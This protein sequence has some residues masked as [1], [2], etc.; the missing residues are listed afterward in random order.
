MTPH[1]EVKLYRAPLASACSVSTRR[2]S[3]IAGSTA[4]SGYG[5]LEFRAVT[6]DGKLGV[7]PMP[8]VKGGTA[9]N[10]WPEGSNGNDGFGFTGAGGRGSLT[11]VK[12]AFTRLRLDGFEPPGL[13]IPGT[14]PCPGT[15]PF[16][17]D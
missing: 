17:A 11:V 15:R 12:L 10:S 5:K 6:T 4:G 13:R 8:M 16:A 7:P 9:K 14:I 1:S 3:T 2:R